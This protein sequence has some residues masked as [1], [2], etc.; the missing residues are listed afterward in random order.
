[1]AKPGLSNVTTAQ[2]FQTWLDRTNDIVN[3]IQTEVMT[4]SALTDTTTGNAILIGDFTAN[5]IVAFDLLRVDT[6]SPKSGSS[7]VAFTSPISVTSPTSTA[8]TLIST[9]GPRVNYTSGPVTWRAGFEDTTNNNF[10]IDT[11]VGARKFLL[12]PSGNLTVAGTITGLG[13]FI[14]NSTTATKLETART[15]ELIGDVTGSATFDGSTNAVITAVVV[16]DSHNHIISNVD[17]LQTALDSKALKAGDSNQDFSAKTLNATTIDL[18]NWTITESGGVLYFATSGVNKMK[19][20]ASG[21][22]TVT[23]DVTG[24]GT[25]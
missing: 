4:A 16:D 17:G 20:D 7:T 18:G 19:L 2:T 25:I 9:N 10:M 24:F 11:G 15:I 5:N 6:V 14:G 3:L 8:T 12:S 23:G 13:G 21:N 1:M 22:L